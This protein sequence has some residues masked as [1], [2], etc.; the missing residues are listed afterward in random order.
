VE[1]H[2]PLAGRDLRARHRQPGAA[3]VEH[4]HALAVGGGIVALATARGTLLVFDALDGDLV[5]SHDL[6]FSSEPSAIAV[7]PRGDFIAV[8]GDG[9]QIVLLRR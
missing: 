9:G 5:Q 6:R 2:A 4:H 1:P 8:G 3:S 7:S